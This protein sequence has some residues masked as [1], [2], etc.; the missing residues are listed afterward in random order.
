MNEE[1]KFNHSF[2]LYLE[3][4]VKTYLLKIQQTISG[5][6]KE[7]SVLFI[8]SII[9]WTMKRYNEEAVICALSL[10]PPVINGKGED[11]YEKWHWIFGKIYM[12]N[13]D[14]Q[15]L[16]GK[17]GNFLKVINKEEI[18]KNW[19]K[20]KT[21]I[22]TLYVTD[23]VVDFIKNADDEFNRHFDHL[24]L[25][26]VF[27]HWL[28]NDI[29]RSYT[30]K[31]KIVT[32]KLMGKH[33]GYITLNVD[34]RKWLEYVDEEKKEARI[35][36]DTLLKTDHTDVAGINNFLALEAPDSKEHDLD[37]EFSCEGFYQMDISKKPSVKNAEMI[38]SGKMG[39][40][41][42]RTD[43]YTLI[44]IEKDE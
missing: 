2:V 13:N 21:D 30:Q 24:Y 31:D 25:S 10:S 42:A 16:V 26:D 15:L 43:H 34:Q 38:I 1:A 5:L 32:S 35:A 29:Y 11:D 39:D 40:F 4:G 14:L 18:L 27:V 22:S 44:K 12:M 3:Q 41:Y 8:E 7:E 23:D 6:N 9:K 36:F 33:F 37:Y 20:V 17:H 19:E 28:F